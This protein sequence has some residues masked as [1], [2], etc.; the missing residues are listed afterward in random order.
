[1]SPAPQ[2]QAKVISAAVET[3]ALFERWIDGW[4]DND[5]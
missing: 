5:D 2:A 3:F 1:V 4:N